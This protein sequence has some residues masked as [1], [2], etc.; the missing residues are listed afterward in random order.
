MLYELNSLDGCHGWFESDLWYKGRIFFNCIV[1]YRKFMFRHY[2][3]FWK[4]R[5]IW[6]WGCEGFV[7]RHLVYLYDFIKRGEDCHAWMNRASPRRLQEPSLVVFVA[8]SI[9]YHCQ[10][11]SSVCLYP[12]CN[13]F[14]LFLCCYFVLI[15]VYFKLFH[16]WVTVIRTCFGLRGLGM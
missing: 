4:C 5:T 9:V 2:E 13:A 6:V 3:I 7:M 11:W 8:H 14:V 15:Y 10:W 12:S 16:S 1:A